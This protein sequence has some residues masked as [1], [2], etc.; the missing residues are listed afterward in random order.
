MPSPIVGWLHEHLYVVVFLGAVLDAI[1]VPFPGR[2]MLITAG[3][4]S[5][6]ASETSSSAVAVIALAAAGMVAGDHVWYLAG[7]L[8]G[9]RLFEIYCRLLRLSESHRADADWILRRFGGLAL[10]LVRLAATL[11]L[12]VVPLA[13]SRGM[14]YGRFVV[15]DAIG[16]TLWATGFVGLGRAVGAVAQDAGIGIALTLLSVLV[17]GSAALSLLARRRLAVSGM[18]R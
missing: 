8:K 3:S 7:R 11:R 5:H 18:V 17:T 12:L 1:G 2:L 6:P 16:A 14:S 4:F 15:S 13:V 9:R 10:V